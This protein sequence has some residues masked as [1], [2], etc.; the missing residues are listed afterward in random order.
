MARQYRRACTMFTA[1]AGLVCLPALVH[2]GVGGGFI[3]L[4]E[5]INIVSLGVGQVPDYQGSDDYDTAVGPFA[6]YYFSGQRYI[7][8]L[9]PQITL[10]ILD[11]KVLQFGPMLVYR[12]GR[13]NDVEDTVVKQMREIDDTVE[14][15]AFMAA[16]YQLSDDPRN[17]FIL[18]ADLVGDT[19]DTHEGYVGTVGARLW[20][21][22]HQAVVMHVG[23]GFAYSSEDYTQT[24]YG[25][26]G[27]DI[28]LFPSLGGAAYNPDGGITDV[29][30]TLG[31]V[32][33]LSREWQ[34]GVG[35]RYQGLM[36][37][38][39]D[40]PVVAERGDSAQWIYGMG[41]GYAWE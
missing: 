1:L 7:N 26:S 23:G 25:V 2:A 34:L 35:A 14:A 3:E 8:V 18:S 20:M 31:A 5:G 22:V 13:N 17:R 29:R 28:A 12:F 10:N 24:Y 41:L 16:S 11:D 40:S 37:D 32:V 19:G 36:N 38:A 15:G 9:G 21:P 30:A 4:E 33:H 39:E 6:R 27:T